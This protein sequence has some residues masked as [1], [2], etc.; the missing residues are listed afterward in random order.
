MAV[1]LANALL[2]SAETGTDPRMVSAD[3]EVILDYG[4]DVED[5]STIE[6]LR[7]NLR[8]KV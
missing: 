3:L 7:Q 2:R 5:A 4:L 8:M 1:F 6:K